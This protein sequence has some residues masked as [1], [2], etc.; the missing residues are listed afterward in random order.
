MSAG[1]ADVSAEGAGA[2][3]HRAAIDERVDEVFGPTELILDLPQNTY[4]QLNDG[5][6]II[7]KGSVW[8]RPGSLSVLPSHMSGD[9]VLFRA[10]QKVEDIRSS[11]SHGTGR[12]MSRSASK[13]LAD[14]YD[15]AKLRRSVLIPSGVEDASLRTDGPFAYRDLDECLALIGDYVEVVV[16]FALVGYMG[17]L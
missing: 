17:H 2:A 16:R 11:L 10:K 5:G 6:V 8:L 4:E 12:A 13:P 7:R 9:V 14:S 1:I 15:F 3:D